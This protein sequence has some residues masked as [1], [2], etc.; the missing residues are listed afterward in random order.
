MGIPLMAFVCIFIII[1]NCEN[2]NTFSRIC[3]NLVVFVVF[4]ML[5]LLII[6]KSAG[7]TNA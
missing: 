1:R 2:V 7:K 6:N 3:E 4:F 5:F